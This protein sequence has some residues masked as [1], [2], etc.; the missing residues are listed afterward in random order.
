M[1][2]TNAVK[3]HINYL[4]KDKHD[5]EFYVALLLYDVCGLPIDKLNNEIISKTQ[6]IIDDFDSIY[7]DY[8]RERVREEVYDYDSEYI[9]ENEEIEK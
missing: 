4:K 6:K 1:L 7:N 9:E 2:D 3:E 5:R 8:L